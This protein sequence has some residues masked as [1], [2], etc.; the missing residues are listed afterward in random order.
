MAN[1]FAH[2]PAQNF[3]RPLRLL[4]CLALAMLAAGGLSGCG[5]GDDSAAAAASATLT[6]TAATG[7]A[8]ANAELTATNAKGVSVKVRTG[9][10]GSYTLNIAEAAPYLLSI[11]DAAGKLWYSYAAQAGTAN[12]TPLTT[13][14][15]LD[16]YGNKPLADLAKAWSASALTSDA[17]LASAAKVNAHFK[18]LMANQGL[19]AAS[20]NIFATPFAANHTGLDAVLDAMRVAIDC[21][22]SSCV[23][24]IRSPAGSVLV[25]WNGNIATTGITLSWTA[26]NAAGGSTGGGAV[27]VGLGSCKAPKA[28]SYSMVVKT[29]VAGLAGVSVPEVCIDGLPGKPDSQAAFCGSSDVTTQL[30]AGVVIKS[31]SYSGNTGTI[32]AQITSPVVLDYTVSYTFVMP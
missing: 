32:A 15:L 29:T 7:A 31:C 10:D 5:G 27:T 3:H 4:S 19:N 21:S 13:L 28:G 16:A 1:R 24:S 23:Q 14:A 30:P 25:G 11:G 18:T 26:T 12:I 9:A 20:H 6:G 8:I 2:H 22:A 17:V